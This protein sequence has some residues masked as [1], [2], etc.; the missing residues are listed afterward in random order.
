MTTRPRSLPMRSRAS[1][2]GISAVASSRVPAQLRRGIESA[3][4]QARCRCGNPGCDVIA[5]FPVGASMYCRTTATIIA[6]CTGC[7]Q[8]RT[9]C[10]C[11]MG[12][13]RV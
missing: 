8:P 10:V 3:P 5:K 6:G 4:A 9:A 2:C 12:V 11:L 13:P 7:N 1:K